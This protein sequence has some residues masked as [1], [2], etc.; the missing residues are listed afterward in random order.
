MSPS[1]K[2]KQSS[3]KSNILFCPHFSTFFGGSMVTLAPSTP[4]RG[5]NDMNSDANWF[6]MISDIC[7]CM[8]HQAPLGA[9]AL[10]QVRP[11]NVQRSPWC[12]HQWRCGPCDSQLSVVWIGSDIQRWTWCN[13]FITPWVCWISASIL[14][15]PNFGTFW[16]PRCVFCGNNLCFFGPTTEACRMPSINVPS[17]AV[18]SEVIYTPFKKPVRQNVVYTLWMGWWDPR[19]SSLNLNDLIVD[20]R[21]FKDSDFLISCLL[22]ID[23]LGSISSTTPFSIIFHWPNQ[24]EHYWIHIALFAQMTAPKLGLGGCMRPKTQCWLFLLLLDGN[25][26]QIQQTIPSGLLPRFCDTLQ[27]EIDAWTAEMW[28]YPLV[29]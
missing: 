22:K 20:T 24:V 14:W 18:A 25:P 28:M 26:Q 19:G 15:D 27:S 2:L 11:S 17:A 6:T 16:D 21:S 1:P 23:W 9:P 4:S 7:C 29:N 12:R 13:T 8:C 5:L 3:T 10:H